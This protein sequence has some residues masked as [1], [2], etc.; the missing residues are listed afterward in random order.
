MITANP[1]VALIR[2]GM[3]DI[4]IGLGVF[5]PL[6]YNKPI[7]L[8]IWFKYFTDTKYCFVLS[9]TKQPYPFSNCL[10]DSTD[11]LCTLNYYFKNSNMV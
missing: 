10:K 11:T 9:H 5:I 8:V 4:F 6:G 1:R 3:R 2:Q 7:G